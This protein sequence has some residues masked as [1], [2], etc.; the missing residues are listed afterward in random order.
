M[1]NKRIVHAMSDIDDSLIWEAQADVKKTVKVS[2]VYKWGAVAAC[3]ALCLAM[4]I[5]LPMMLKNDDVMGGWDTESPVI[6]PIVGGNIGG[7][8][9][10][11]N[12]IFVLDELNGRYKDENIVSSESGYIIEWPWD[13]LSDTERYIHIDFN[14]KEYTSRCRK[15]SQE[16]LEEC[17]GEGDGLGYENTSDES[18]KHT[19]SLPVYKIK[20]VSTDAAVAVDFGGEYYVYFTRDIEN[21]ATLGELMNM[22]GF[23]ETVKLEKYTLYEGKDKKGYYRIES[24]DFIMNVLKECKDAPAMQ[25]DM[26][27]EIIGD[28]YAAF[29]VTSEALGIYKK[30]LYISS[31]GYVFS[32][33]MEY[34]YTYNIGADMAARLM[35]YLKGENALESAFEPYNYS[36]CGVVKEI[37][38]DYIMIDDSIMCEKISDGIILKVDMTDSDCSRYIKHG[39]AKAGDVVVISFEGKIQVDANNMIVGA[40]AISKAQLVMGDVLIPE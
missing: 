28:E 23:E 5:C 7:N 22:L 10:S 20:N 33:I 17:L 8:T 13:E 25:D 38:E 29:S 31:L 4:A 37:G 16:L 40:V 19:K 27:L 35:D 11:S 15:M 32:N 9:G 3:F 6:D 36:L 34:G 39:Y 24:D 12:G 21:P 26:T 30:T 1:K 2:S 18:I 14:G